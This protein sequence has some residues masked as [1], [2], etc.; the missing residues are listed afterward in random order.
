MNKVKLFANVSVNAKSLIHQ[1][2]GSVDGKKNLKELTV[3]Q[4]ET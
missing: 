1:T 3:K 2:F 4:M